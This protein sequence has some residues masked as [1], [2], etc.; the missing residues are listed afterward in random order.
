MFRILFI[1]VVGGIAIG[2]LGQ[3]CFKKNLTNIPFV[4][5]FLGFLRFVAFKTMTEILLEP[6]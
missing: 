1:R 4:I 6:L 5:N 3:H 2:M